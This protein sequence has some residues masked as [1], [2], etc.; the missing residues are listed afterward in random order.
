MCPHVPE[1]PRNTAAGPS[2]WI[3]CAAAEL[4]PPVAL[5]RFERGLRCGRGSA[6]NGPVGEVEARAVTRTYDLLAL[7]I[8]V[9]ER[10]AAV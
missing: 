4:E 10:A 7:E 2:G 1:R 9:G 3:D 5:A 6:Q 8:T